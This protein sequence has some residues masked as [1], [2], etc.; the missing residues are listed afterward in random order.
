VSRIL[1]I[2][3]WVLSG[4][5]A[6]RQ[7]SLAAA[8]DRANDQGAEVS[9]TCTETVPEV[10]GPAESPRICEMQVIG[11][12]PRVL[13]G[14]RVVD[15][16]TIELHAPPTG[17]AE[18]VKGQC[19]GQRLEALG[20]TLEVGLRDGTVELRARG[21]ARLYVWDDR[22]EI[23]V[24]SRAIDSLGGIEGWAR[25]WLVWA[26][27]W[28]VDAQL[29]R[30]RVLESAD[31]IG[32]SPVRVDIAADLG[33]WGP[34]LDEHQDPDR[35]TQKTVPLPVPAGRGRLDSL[36]LGQVDDNP[37]SAYGYARSDKVER[38][39]RG[40]AWL[41]RLR[42][43]GRS[44]GEPVWRWELRLRDDAL[45]LRRRGSDEVV[46]D[47]RKC[48]TLKDQ[49]A[50]A[51]VW[52]HAFGRTDTDT[53]GHYRLVV[54]AERFDDKGRGMPAT[55]VRAVD[56]MWRLVQTAGGQAPVEGL[57]QVRERKA[58]SRDRWRQ[59]ADELTLRGLA[60]SV[61]LDHD[62]IDGARMLAL[63][64]AGRLIEGEQFGEA[65][66]RQR[67]ACQDLRVEVGHD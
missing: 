34:L 50:I 10:I 65:F 55:R 6:L 66:E 47:L 24:G 67:S 46:V 5:R 3:A 31:E 37:L 33:S 9:I 11:A 21:Q 61:A 42:Q 22:V 40:E 44:P 63:V 7:R 51:R 25:E 8:T 28:L 17:W 20:K 27:A 52:A 58:V 2:L 53:H 29:D 64:R 19:A 38:S 36:A 48:A 56:P 4:I 14:A 35:W 30:D 39:G 43:A 13:V 26:S 23:V 60:A 59:D 62:S 49:V 16:T 32:W 12:D 45:Q 54:P 18:W 57:A 15:Q 1:A 41:E